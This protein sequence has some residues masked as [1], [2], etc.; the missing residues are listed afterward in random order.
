MTEVAAIRRTV[1]GGPEEF[2]VYRDNLRAAQEI[3]K[4]V[5]EEAMETFDEM[6]WKMSENGW[7]N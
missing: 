1:L 7:Q 5:V 4:P 2:A 3:A 6:I